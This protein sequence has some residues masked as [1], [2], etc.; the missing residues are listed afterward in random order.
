MTGPSQWQVRW[1]MNGEGWPA[2]WRTLSTTSR[3]QPGSFRTHPAGRRMG[4][5][6][7]PAFQRFHS[8][9]GHSI[10]PLQGLGVL[11][12]SCPTSDN[13]RQPT[14]TR[15]LTPLVWATHRARNV[16]CEI[17]GGRLDI[18]CLTSQRKSVRG[19]EGGS[20]I[21]LSA[22]MAQ[23]MASPRLPSCGRLAF[24]R[25]SVN[26]M[27][28]SVTITRPLTEGEMGT[29]PTEVS[30]PQEGQQQA[31]GRSTMKSRVERV[32]SASLLGGQPA[33]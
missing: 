24:R 13:G 3:S 7:A 18:H 19:P 10:L 12:Y 30:A 8:A 28:M 29:T 33:A 5:L 1:R 20:V 31:Q 16:A 17:A 21:P 9:N 27:L 22:T 2:L 23:Q 26:S 6:H 32:I 15:P 25:H 4:R 14:P 11:T